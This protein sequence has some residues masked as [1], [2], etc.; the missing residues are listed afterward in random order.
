MTPSIFEAALDYAKNGLHVFPVKANGKTPLTAHGF[1]DATIDPE[2]IATW[3]DEYP[4]AN[5]GIATGTS[6]LFVIDV[7]V[8]DGK[9]GLASFA[10]L[11]RGVDLSHVPTVRTPSGGVHYYFADPDG[12]FG[13]TAGTLGD[14]IDTRGRGGYVVAPPS[15]IDGVAYVWDE[16]DQ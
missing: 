5:V 12:E 3:W 14:G 8:K 2:Q 9:P 11:A 7:D 16:P 6:G 15:I 4:G 10:K 13:I 1:K